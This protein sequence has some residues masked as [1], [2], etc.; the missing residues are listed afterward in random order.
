MRFLVGET[1]F[2]LESVLSLS[3]E[4]EGFK[5]HPEVVEIRRVFGSEPAVLKSANG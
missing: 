3:I 2:A 4:W 1:E 5:M